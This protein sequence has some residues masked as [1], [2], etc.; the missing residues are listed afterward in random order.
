[1]Y[2]EMSWRLA[3]AS[4]MLGRPLPP[5]NRATKAATSASMVC[6]RAS[7]RTLSTDLIWRRSASVMVLARTAPSHEMGR[8]RMLFC[9]A[10]MYAGG[11]SDMATT[12]GTRSQGWRADDCAVPLRLRGRDGRG[13]GAAGGT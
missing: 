3:A 12:S 10:K 4:K 5:S 11:S 8:A 13:R 2:C 6:L 9:S 7:L 1:M